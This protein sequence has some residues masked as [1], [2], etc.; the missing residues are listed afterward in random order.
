MQVWTQHKER[1]VT[2]RSLFGVSRFLAALS[3]YARLSRRDSFSRA[4]KRSFRSG[5]EFFGSL[6]LSQERWWKKPT[7]KNI[8]V[9]TGE[10]PSVWCWGHLRLAASTD[11]EKCNKEVTQQP[12]LGQ[13]LVW[14]S[15]SLCRPIYCSQS[16][17]N[18]HPSTL[19]II[20]FK[21]AL[22]N[23]GK[24]TSCETL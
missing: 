17:R 15:A 14:K 19:N 23:C 12:T 7:H 10:F 8:T 2:V 18:V 11:S 4:M 3:F 5:H 6:S 20:Y 22:K 13:I 16:Q 21:A 24:S 9:G 1:F